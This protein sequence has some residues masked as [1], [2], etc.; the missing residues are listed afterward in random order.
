MKTLLGRRRV[1]TFALGLVLTLAWTPARGA[2]EGMIIDRVVAVIDGTPITL[3]ELEFEARVALVG[4][5]A[6]RAAT[7]PLDDGTL[8][9]AL[10]YA[11]SER[12]QASEADKLQAW[13]VDPAEVETAVRAFR[14]RF[15]SPAEFE[16]FLARHEADLQQLGAVLERGLRA[17][18][19]LESKVRLRAQ[20]SE[21]EVRSYFDAHASELSGTYDEL[22]VALKEK[23]VRERYQK[24]VQTELEQLRG[25][26][27]VRRVAKF[28]VGEDRG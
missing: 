13:R 22:R 15:A 25:T 28:A 17:S 6:V 4:R 9:S 23:L 26:H 12:L 10:E 3:S 2:E 1:V 24:L 20:V 19:M 14:E 27:D 5:G 8:A 11:I 7:E 18:R 21:A 16:A